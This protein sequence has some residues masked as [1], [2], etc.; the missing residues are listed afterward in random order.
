VF[1]EQTS[2]YIGEIATLQEQLEGTAAELQQKQVKKAKL[3]WR[4]WCAAV[5]GVVK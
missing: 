4:P 2:S 5:V 3:P 1:A